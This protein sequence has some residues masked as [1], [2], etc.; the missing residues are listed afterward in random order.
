MARKSETPQE[1]EL[2]LEIEPSDLE[3]V[4][5]HPLLQAGTGNEPQKQD[6][7][8]T[9]FDTPDHALKQAG[10]S[11]RIR[12]NGTQRIQT[13]KA[14]Q[15][16]NGVALTRGEWEHKVD[17][18]KPD[19]SAAEKTALKPFVQLQDRIGPVFSVTAERTLREI[20]FGLS[21][22]EVAV[23]RGTVDG[24]ALPLP[25]GEL[26]LELKQGSPADLFGLARTLA[27]AAPLRLS[28]KT[29]AER[30]FE[31]ISRVVPNRVKAEPVTLKRRMTSAQAFQSI[32]ASCL[33][34]LMANEALV[35]QAPEAD[36][37]H[38]MRV[39]LRRLRA[40]ITLFKHVVADGR[41]DP[42]KAELK[43]MA[44][45]L[46]VAR[47]LDVYIQKVLEPA[48]AQHQDDKSYTALLAYYRK[49]RK[50]AYR[51]VQETIASGRFVN[52][53]LEVAA[54]VQAGDWLQ[55]RS[56]PA[57]QRRKQPVVALA[58]QELGRRW[59]RILKRGKHLAKLEPEERHQVRIEIKKL[60]YATEFFENLFKGGGAKKR[61]RAALKTLETMQETLGG[62]NDIAVGFEMNSSP[63]AVAIH[64]EQMA[65]VDGLLAAAKKQ[66]RDFA[67]LQPFWS[68]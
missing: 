63:A 45:V 66:Y 25:F 36:T 64:E 24:Q 59:K 8:S 26:E 32:G 52:G 58:E 56:K 5:A 51:M 6:L 31:T 65:R 57:R 17:G 33:R 7:H 1:V 20:P 38:Q 46:G 15:A 61:R 23:D 37:V 40:A 28:F 41:R 60:R 3:T 67:A 39:A 55:D 2:K 9:Y 16:Q 4:L 22:I 13:V 54:W 68:V 10:L 42:I 11:L 44:N 21:V 34:H 12:H 35:R 62:L 19:F 27:M 30:G 49:R 29:K 47:D 14:A 53:I 18:D 48:Q 43:W 50:Q